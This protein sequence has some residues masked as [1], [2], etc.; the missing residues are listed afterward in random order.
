MD[1]KAAQAII[2]AEKKRII[3][4]QNDLKTK[5]DIAELNRLSIKASSR[6]GSE[7]KVA[8]STC[9]KCHL[10]KPRTEMKLV[11]KKRRSGSSIGYGFKSKNISVRAYTSNTQVWVCDKC[12]SWWE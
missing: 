6:T 3:E 11:T 5:S 8:R 7:E 4:E 9:T 1:A 2:D 12:R 10:I